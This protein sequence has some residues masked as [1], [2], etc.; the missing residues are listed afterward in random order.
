MIPVLH[1]G[2]DGMCW[3]GHG[4]LDCSATC[5]HSARDINK[6]NL[7]SGQTWHTELT[8]ANGLVVIREDLHPEIS[9]NLSSFSTC[10]VLGS[11]V[12]ISPARNS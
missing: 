4:E 12:C 11:G 5:A 7:D 9:E 8:F 2:E 10:H 3:A 6:F 1:L